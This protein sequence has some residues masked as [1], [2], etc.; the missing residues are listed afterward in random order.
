MISVASRRAEEA[1]AACHA[2][3]VLLISVEY[4]LHLP[5]GARDTLINR[6]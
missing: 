2:D 4:S 5:R 1:Q 3:V 6:A